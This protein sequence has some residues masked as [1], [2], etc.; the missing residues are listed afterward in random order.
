MH[1]SI[2]GSVSTS[3]DLSVAI[4][5]C[6]NKEM[7]LELSLNSGWDKLNINCMGC[8]A[9]DCSFISDFTNEKEVLFFGGFGVFQFCSI[10]KPTGENYRVYIHAMVLISQFCDNTE[11][12]RSISIK[13]DLS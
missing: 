3:T 12:S 4:N 13:R 7:A 6:A 8:C 5:V 9:L 1:T 10:F 2:K 11:N